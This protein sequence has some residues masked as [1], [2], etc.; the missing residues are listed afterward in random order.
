MG[1]LRDLVESR[2][3]STLVIDPGVLGQPAV[4]ADI[5]REEVARAGGADLSDLIASGDK[6][7][8]IQ[9]MIDGT[10]RLAVQLYAQGKLGGVLAVGGGQG[11]AIGTAGM[12]ALPIGVPKLMVSTMASGQNFFEPYVG[13]ADVTLMHS[14][15][16]ILGVN[17]VTRK[18]FANAAA[19][20]TAMVEAAAQVRESKRTS[21]GASMLGL[22][23]PCL[24]HTRELL[25]GW[26]SELIA[27]H[28][29]GTGGR[30]IERLIHEGVLRGVLDISL[31][32]LTGQVCSGIFDAGPDR[33]R[34][35]GRHGFP[36]VVAPGGTD[37]IVLGPLPSLTQ[38]QRD[39]A[40]IVHNSNI[41]LV[42]TAEREMAAIGQVMAERLN[43]AKGP[44]AV[45]IPLHGF[46]SADRQGHPF[47][48][49]QA[50]GALVAALNDALDPSIPFTRIKAHI[51]DNAFAEAVAASLRQLMEM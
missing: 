26:E 28:A 9:T 36:Q 41:T 8:A 49:P 21:L 46:S 2:G 7:Y 11:T 35:A 19:A 14:V 44:V 50:D 20:I 4:E 51:N 40:L 16:D 30:S 47:H 24:L 33:M 22:T 15:A 42:R 43:E 45:L 6:G 18:V 37:Y 13:T 1:Y 5:S 34:T 27:F 31:Q 17:A 23:T 39:R 10:R 29:N 25:E 48:D 3:G 38:E 32:E 12:K